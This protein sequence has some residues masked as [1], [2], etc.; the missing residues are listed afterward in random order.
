MKWK[1]YNSEDKS[2]WP[3]K[4]DRVIVHAIHTWWGATETWI[5]VDRWQKIRNG[6]PRWDFS[7]DV[8]D[9]IKVTHWMPLPSAPEEDQDDRR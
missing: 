5:C 4:G 1:K 3:K 8:L 6:E 7:S 2:T 9:C